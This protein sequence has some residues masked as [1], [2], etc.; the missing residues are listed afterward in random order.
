MPISILEAMS[1]GLPV[2]TTSATGCRDLIENDVNGFAV[3]VGDVP[4]LTTA[5]LRLA[6]DSQLRESLG[7]NGREL[8]VRDFEQTRVNSRFVDF[9]EAE[10]LSAL[11][12]VSPRVGN[13]A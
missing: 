8:V 11:A 10:N 4:A 2:V 1:T 12:R 3:P 5:L 6:E 7:A 13:H 9:I